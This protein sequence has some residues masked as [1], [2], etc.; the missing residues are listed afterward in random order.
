MLII[1]DV[2]RMHKQLVKEHEELMSNHGDGFEIKSLELEILR[3]EALL[4]DLGVYF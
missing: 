1:K 4:R 3:A 2:K